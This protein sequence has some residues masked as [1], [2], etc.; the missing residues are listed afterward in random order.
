VHV[1]GRIDGGPRR[2]RIS[3]VALVFLLALLLLP[4]LAI[5]RLP[6]TVDLRYVW[7]Y[8]L[9]ISIV[10]YLHYWHDKRRAL[11]GGWRTPESTLHINELLGGWPGAFLAQRVLRHKIAKTS[12][13][14]KYWMIVTLHQFAAF[15]FARDWQYSRKMLSLIYS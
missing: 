6:Q 11:S 3:W 13:Q 12:F 8:A 7:S 5:G 2:G 9:F 10:T 15:D 4:A 14:V 1:N